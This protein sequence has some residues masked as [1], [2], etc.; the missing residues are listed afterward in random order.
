VALRVPPSVTVADLLAEAL[1]TVGGDLETTTRWLLARPKGDAL[2]PEE[3]IGRLGLADG[4]LLVIRP[5]VEA[6][7]ETLSEDLPEAV[8]GVVEEA[9]G[10][11]TVS[12]V[13]L[14][15][16]AAAGAAV[17]AVAASLW[18]LSPS[19]ERVAVAVPAGLVALA[20]GA[21]ASRTQ[22]LSRVGRW[23]ALSGLA[24]WAVGGAGTVAES[25]PVAAPTAAA[26]AV[27]AG[28]LAIWFSVKDARNQACACALGAAIVGV[29]FAATVPVKASTD[30]GA[31]IVVVLGLMAIG[32]L[33]MVSVQMAGLLE[34]DS[35]AADA[36][37]QLALSVASGRDVLGW[38][39]LGDAFVLVGA[40]A[41]LA[42]GVGPYA[43]A[44]AGV[45]AL[46][47]ILQARHHGFRTEAAPLAL[48]AVMMVAVVE[49]GVVFHGI[50]TAWAPIAGAGIALLDVVVAV[51]VVESAGRFS[52]S[53]D[54]R[55]WFGILEFLANAAIVPLFLGVIGL[56]DVVFTQAKHLL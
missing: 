23:V 20:F 16:A 35:S 15:G 54:S 47:T 37:R 55:R 50:Q 40:S 12:D 13:A 6:E 32:M 29:G 14:L 46:A 2:D 52:S 5:A 51:I 31:G 27:L 11:W 43:P 44:L 38:L 39:I 17:L 45:A 53:V 21:A 8:A 18:Q 49:F 56:Y 1:G 30:V 25:L 10:Q 36:K 9:P 19:L 41:V 3:T 7:E 33:P 34:I 42:V 26:L 28:A 22:V 24:L 4:T 48:A